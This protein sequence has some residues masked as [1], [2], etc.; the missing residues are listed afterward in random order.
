MTDEVTV[1]QA[2]DLSEASESQPSQSPQL[3]T[4]EPLQGTQETAEAATESGGDSES[5][6]P[7]LPT[8]EYQK[9]NDALINSPDGVISDELKAEAYAIGEGMGLPKA[10]VDDYMA[11]CHSK[12]TEASTKQQAEATQEQEYQAKINQII[13]DEDSFSV[14]EDWASKSLS[15]SEI[16]ELNNRIAKGGFDGVM[17]VQYVKTMYEQ[18][19]GTKSGEP[20]LFAGST[21]GTPEGESFKTEAEYFAAMGKKDSYGN[22][23]YYTDAQYRNQVQQKWANYSNKTK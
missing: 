1:S 14:I 8:W 17:A 18:A 2:E 5:A 12:L 23:L 21:H 9:F 19:T 4:S 10:T 16:Q 22:K 6:A 7:D 15:Q 11:F 20:K 3:D 13:G